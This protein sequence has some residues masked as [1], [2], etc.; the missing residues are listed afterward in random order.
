[1]E[2]GAGKPN[3]D[4]LSWV[5]LLLFLFINLLLVGQP[6]TQ[7]LQLFVGESNAQ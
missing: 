6:Q 2:S 7:M 1:V 3:S 4:L 5:I